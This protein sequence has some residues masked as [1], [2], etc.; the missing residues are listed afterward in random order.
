MSH[1]M[2]PPPALELQGQREEVVGPEPRRQDHPAGA[3]AVDEPGRR[4]W[5]LEAEDISHFLEIPPTAGCE[6]EI[7]LLFPFSPFPI[8]SAQQFHF[9]ASLRERNVY[10]YTGN[11]TQ[12]GF[13][14]TA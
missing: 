11:H 12:Q 10:V 4:S 9:S 13:H 7:S 2:E 3:G 5:S 6:E 14:N 8:F 1:C